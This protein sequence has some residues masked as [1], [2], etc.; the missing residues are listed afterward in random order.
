M[1][2][3]CQT[4]VRKIWRQCNLNQRNWFKSKKS[5][6]L[7]F[8]KKITIYIHPNKTCKAPV[9]SSPPT[10]QHPVFLQ[11]GCPSCR[12]TNSV[13][14]LKGNL[15]HFQ[16]VFY[17]YRRENAETQ[18]MLMSSIWFVQEKIAKHHAR[19]RQGEDLNAKILALK[20]F[21]NPRYFDCS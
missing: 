9:K 6:F 12:P 18:W 4:F 2:G 20:E 7:I 15:Y 19:L 14:A 8:I 17:S 13:K 16:C 10:N 21:R 1:S 11:A 3:K 5:D